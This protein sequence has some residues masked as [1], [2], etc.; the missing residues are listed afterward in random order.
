[1]LQLLRQQR[2]AGA[3]LDRHQRSVA[4]M[5]HAVAEKRRDGNMLQVVRGLARIAAAAAAWSSWVEWVWEVQRRL[6]AATAT[7]VAAA[8]DRGTCAAWLTAALTQRGRTVVAAGALTA[9][10][11]NSAV[12]AAALCAPHAVGEAC[13]L[14]RRAFTTATPVGVRLSLA[15][16]A[17]QVRGNRKL[18]VPLPLLHERRLLL[19]LL[20]LV[21][22]KMLT[23]LGLLLVVPVLLARLFLPRDGFRRGFAVLLPSLE[24]RRIQALGA[25]IL[26][27]VQHLVHL[28]FERTQVRKVRGQS[29]RTSRRI[30]IAVVTVAVVVV[31]TAA[32]DSLLRVDRFHQKGR[33]RTVCG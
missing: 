29:S 24:Q 19:M 26:Q 31:V 1:M 7:A 17:N 9:C 15:A 13:L 22:V 33:G 18:V 25:L 30:A 8:S 21:V 27:H 23:L 11:S 2:G 3:A 14:R 20:L 12:A 6:A 10:N 28:A 32:V 16:R 5:R 4:K